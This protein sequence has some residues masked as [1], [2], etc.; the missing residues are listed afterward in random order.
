M[1]DDGYQPPL[2]PPLP[3]PPVTHID[4]RRALVERV[5]ISEAEAWEQEHD[6]ERVDLFW[7]GQPGIYPDAGG[8]MFSGLRGGRKSTVRCPRS[9]LKDAAIRDGMLFAGMSANVVGTERRGRQKESPP[10]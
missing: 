6:L 3:R 4:G 8:V 5:R 1:P 2:L 9:D 10:S 7:F